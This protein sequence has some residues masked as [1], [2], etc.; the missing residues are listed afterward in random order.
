MLNN[1]NDIYHF[2]F[3]IPFLKYI[4][5]HVFANLDPSE[6]YLPVGVISELRNKLESELDHY[7][8]TYNRAVFR[9]DLP[10]KKHLCMNLA[11]AQLTEDQCRILA[12]YEL[13][14]RKYNVSF[15]V[16]QKPLQIQYTKRITYD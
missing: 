4:P 16:Y 15:V 10:A 13:K 12:M 8:M 9:T 1:A 14:V 5:Q 7:V 2:G 11:G 6:F 3:V